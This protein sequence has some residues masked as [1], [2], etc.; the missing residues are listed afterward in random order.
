[1]LKGR[2]IQV[3]LEAL[4]ETWAPSPSVES[5]TPNNKRGVF[6]RKTEKKVKKGLRQIGN[7]H[8]RQNMRLVAIHYS[9]VQIHC[10]SLDP[11]GLME[12]NLTELGGSCAISIW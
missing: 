8:L 9:A 2:L 3:H 5:G 10:H 7:H 1:M 6:K 12:L 4:L 11:V